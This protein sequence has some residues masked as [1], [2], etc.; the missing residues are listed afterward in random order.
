MVWPQGVNPGLNY[1]CNFQEVFEL[2][3]SQKKL[4]NA[5]GITLIELLVVITILAI[6]GALA[7]PAYSTYTERS[8]RADAKA[9]LSNIV[10]AEERFFTVNGAYI[11]G[12]DNDVTASG[13]SF[14]RLDLDTNL[15]VDHTSIESEKRYYSIAVCDASSTPA[16]PDPTSSSFTLRATAQNEQA[17]DTDCSY[18]DITHLGVKTAE[19]GG[20]PPANC[21]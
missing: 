18:F 7:I 15:S 19:D 4:N 16:C 6:L 14:K 20:S 11:T 12:S 13:D 8:R 9:A 10:L 5:A 21:W 17:N 1:I 3:A 2:M